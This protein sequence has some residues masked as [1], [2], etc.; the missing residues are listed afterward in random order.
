MARLDLNQKPVRVQEGF[1]D[2]LQHW[3]ISKLVKQLCAL[4]MD[5]HQTVAGWFFPSGPDYEVLLEGYKAL[6]HV[7]H[8]IE[9]RYERRSF[10]KSEPLEGVVGHSDLLEAEV[11]VLAHIVNEG[12][13]HQ[14]KLDLRNFEY[15][16]DHRFRSL[17]QVV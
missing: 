7:A 17:E 9:P 11:R 15:L 8:L 16:L 14:Q 2:R 10:F 5:Q 4:S 13:I 12:L 3:Q 1:T 6:F